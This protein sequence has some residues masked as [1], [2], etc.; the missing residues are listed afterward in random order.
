MFVRSAPPRPVSKP[1]ALVGNGMNT[2][3]VSG[4]SVNEEIGEMLESQRSQAFRDELA[5][6]RVFDPTLARLRGVL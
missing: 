6:F 1:A 4:K 3:A 5:N 2:V